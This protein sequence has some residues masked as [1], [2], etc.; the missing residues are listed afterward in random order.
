MSRK[1][2]PGLRTSKAEVIA[3]AAAA[4]GYRLQAGEIS[5]CRWVSASSDHGEA[6]S[7]VATAAGTSK[8][9]PTATALVGV[10]SAPAEVAEVVQV[11]PGRVP[12]GRQAKLTG[13]EACCPGIAYVRDRGKCWGLRCAADVRYGGKRLSTTPAAPA[14]PGVAAGPEAREDAKRVVIVIIII[15][16]VIGVAAASS[17]QSREFVVEIEWYRGRRGWWRWWSILGSIVGLGVCLDGL[18]IS[19]G[20]REI[21]E[22][23]IELE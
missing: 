15:V 20:R 7:R 5:A 21:L 3:T 12:A 19:L 13:V 8:R 4:A 23:K 18:R 22:G 9:K 14:T 10:L 2:R 11:V 17:T 16:V 1:K 6:A